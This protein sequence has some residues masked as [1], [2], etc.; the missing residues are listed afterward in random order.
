MRTGRWPTSLSLIVAQATRTALSLSF[1]ISL[2]PRQDLLPGRHA[3]TAVAAGA[4]QVLE[5]VVG[6]VGDGQDL[7]AGVGGKPACGGFG[8]GEE[9]LVQAD[10]DVDAVR[11]G[12]HDGLRCGVGVDQRQDR[13]GRLGGH[14][15]NGELDPDGDAAGRAGRLDGE[16]LVQAVG[17]Q[18]RVGGAPAYPYPPAANLV[19]EAGRVV[20]REQV[21]VEVAVAQLEVGGGQAGR[22]RSTQMDARPGCGSAPVAAAT[23]CG[24]TSPT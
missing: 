13:F 8:R 14:A 10:V 12:G 3:V 17:E 23:G 7:P 1:K 21:E 20:L 24:S 6:G 18:E 16:G 9:R 2:N 22:C 15:A 5:A 4:E 19:D 11:V